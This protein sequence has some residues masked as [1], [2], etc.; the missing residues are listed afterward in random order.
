MR[1]TFT[2]T[3]P[4]L[5]LLLLT[6]ACSPQKEKMSHRIKQN[7]AEGWQ[8]RYDAKGAEW[9]NVTL[10]HSA[11]IE[12]LVVNDQWQGTAL[13][14]KTFE[15]EN[16][17]DK[18]VFL[19][20]EGVM[21]E[22]DVWVNSLHL[23][24]HTGGYLPFEVD[25]TNAILPGQQNLLEVRVKNEDNPDIP[26]GK[27][28]KELD[29]NYYGG[30][31]RNVYLITT[32][33]LYI[34]NA[35]AAS[36]PGSGGVLVRFDD[37]SVASAKGWIQVHFKNESKA[38]Q[39][40]HFQA[41]LTNPDKP[42][43]QI[44]SEKTLI[45]PET[46]S[47]LSVEFLVKNP[48]LWSPGQPDLYQLNIVLN[49]NNAPMD[50]WSEKVGIRKIELTDN[51]FFL[52]GEKIYIH[53]T[54]R[55]QE[56]P[57]IGYALSDEAQYRDAV[58]I[59]NA[60]FDFVRLSHYPQAEAF[61]DACDELGLMVM[62]CIPGWQFVGGEEFIEN[63]LQD[64][65]DM[66]R[67]DRNHPSVIFWE[68]SLNETEMPETFIK[69]A[70]Q[71]LK[72]EL[73]FDGIY[74]AGWVDHPA[75][76]L[77]IP[78]RQHGSPPGY[79]NFYKEGKRNVFI[80]E[81]G[82]WEY[83][84][85]NAGFNQTA[86]AGLKEEERT[87]RQLREFGEKRLLQQALNFQEAANSNRKGMAT[88]GDANWVMFDY[89]RGYTD[90]LEAS[91]ISDIFRIPK[92]VYYFY[93]SQRP[94]EIILSQNLFSGPMVRI[95]S[96]WTKDSSTEVKIYSNCEEVE[97][98]LNDSLILRQQPTIDQ[99][100]TH[101]S[102]PPFIFQISKFK[103]GTLRAVGF[104]GDKPVAEH[105]ISTPEKATTIKLEV[106]ITTI[107]I[108]KNT[109]DV[110]FV[111]ALILDENGTIVPDADIKV[112]FSMSGNGELI[113]ENPALAKAGIAAIVLRTENFN[114]P[115]KISASAEGLL[116]GELE[117]IPP[118]E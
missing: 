13:Y 87:S 28:L 32:N 39:W 101:L 60:G 54:N 46:D 51:G 48:R 58:K 3:L 31:Y 37:I 34:T 105:T 6:I 43:L 82:D 74:S 63:S 111:Y 69:R 116:S 113:G 100:S 53:G 36:K 83:Y 40:V 41:H 16:V 78:A 98:L 20:F 19:Y 112:T 68:V 49:A 22:A 52:N 94:P 5:F 81:Y 115:I 42:D 10:P 106:D 104:I 9:E 117:L 109:P 67:R 90:D 62:N 47:E 65:R 99:Y 27:P 76:D 91:G 50:Q 2:K 56:Y 7:F 80:A 114:H 72:T 4:F 38:A 30:I 92:F 108:S 57:Y 95:A 24:H 55:H 89:N 84:A 118:G 107:P 110:V 45:Q 93:Q 75:F 17:T 66:I 15:L 35:V 11:R 26:P 29:F 33:Q 61:M 12:P 86:F 102:Y 97:L 44:T 79:W 25:I 8:F 1:K 14:Q 73:P 88:I 70:T 18:K 85:H 21:H 77:F 23:R 71:I 103:P 96:Y 59:K 64:C